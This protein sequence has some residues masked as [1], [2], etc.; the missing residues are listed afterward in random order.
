[1]MD[2]KNIQ[3]IFS[4]VPQTYE[5]INHILTLGF[6]RVWRQRAARAAVIAGGDR[7]VDMCTG[8]GEMAIY[9]SR[10][11]PRGTKITAVDLSPDMIAA[12]HRKQEAAHIEFVSADIHALP[13]SNESVDLITMSFATRNVNITRESLLYGFAELYRI[14]KPGGLFI[15]LET[16]Q[17]PSGLVRKLFH[18]YVKLFVK[19]IGSKLSGS[20]IAYSYLS[21]TIPRFYPA[22]VLADILHQA[23]FK[24]VT[25]QRLMLGAAAIHHA[26]KALCCVR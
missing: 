6:D 1:M 17:P 16:S 24:E 4:E 13:F 21:N 12:A 7:W 3:D 26:K 25:F 5:M 10:L 23:G 2:T 22:E 11:A 8:T 18:L 19:R 20:K 15:S 14:L 9:L